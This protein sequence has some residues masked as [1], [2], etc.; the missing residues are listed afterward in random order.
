MPGAPKQITAPIS[1]ETLRTL[2]AGDR[3]RI[4]GRLLTARDAAHKRLFE[5]IERGEPLPVDLAGQVIYYVGP[6][7]PKPGQAVGS[8]GPTTSS[9]VDKYTPALLQAGIRGMIGKGYRGA[10]VKEAIVKYGSVYLVAT[11]GTGA[12]LARK[13]ISAR[14][15]AYPDLGTEA[16]RELE[17]EDFPAMV[18]HDARGGDLYA[19]GQAAYRR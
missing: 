5:A 7:P 16:I 1:E 14:V 13:I 4:T 6:T 8:A 18:V 10:E 12:L 3:V 9:R 15:M 2:A 11:G 17:V 19:S